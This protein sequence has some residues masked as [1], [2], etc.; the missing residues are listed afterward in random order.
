NLDR[1]LLIAFDGEQLLECRQHGR[2]ASRKP[3][4]AYRATG[5]RDSQIARWI[6]VAENEPCLA[7]AGEPHEG[8]Q[9]VIRPGRVTGDKAGAA[10]RRDH[11]A[12][13]RG[14]LPPR[15]SCIQARVAFDGDLV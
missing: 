4:E 10:D 7:A 11:G 15:S 9:S 14:N 1:K 5:E 8:A 12:A 13:K 6:G 3:R 2:Y